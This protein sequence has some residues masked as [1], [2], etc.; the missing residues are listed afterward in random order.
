[1]LGDTA[2]LTYK[3]I[4]ARLRKLEDELSEFRDAVQER[5]DDMRITYDV[6]SERWRESDAGQVYQERIAVLDSVVDMLDSAAAE[7]GNYNF[8]D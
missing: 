8:E 5:L 3:A 4:G 7:C 6:R 1:M 2:M